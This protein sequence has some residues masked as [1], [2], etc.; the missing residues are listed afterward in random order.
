MKKIFLLL[1]SLA[2]VFMSSIGASASSDSGAYLPD[3]YKAEFDAMIYELAN[4]RLGGV[5]Y[6]LPDGF[7]DRSQFPMYEQF[8]TIEGV[9]EFFSRFGI[10]IGSDQTAKITNP[11]F[12]DICDNDGEGFYKSECVHPISSFKWFWGYT[13]YYGPDNDYC[14]SSV[15]YNLAM[16]M[17]C[18]AWPVA[19]QYIYTGV[20]HVFL[21]GNGICQRCGYKYGSGD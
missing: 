18:S 6:E 11:L 2:F 1:F 17:A 21:P 20:S 3:D 9:R 19:D 15:T 4:E 7:V 13:D 12:K 5:S 16:C 8:K 14:N 10:D